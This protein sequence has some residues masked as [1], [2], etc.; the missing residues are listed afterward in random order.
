MEGEPCRGR[1]RK[2]WNKY[3]GELFGLDQGEFLM[4]LGA[5]YISLSLSNVNECRESNEYVEGL[6][7]RVLSKHLV[8]K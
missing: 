8:R 5:M 6:N 7:S 2:P 3:V 4:I 1:Q